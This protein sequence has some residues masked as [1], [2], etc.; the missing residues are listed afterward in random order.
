MKVRYE[1]MLIYKL[2]LRLLVEESGAKQIM[3]HLYYIKS[4][5]QLNIFS[6]D[7]RLNESNNH[8]IKTIEE[9]RTRAASINATLEFQS[10]EKGTAVIL[11]V[12]TL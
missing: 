1:L 4:Q 8:V 11:A 7:T 5:L 10:D 6:S 3:I 9:I 12:K 2:T